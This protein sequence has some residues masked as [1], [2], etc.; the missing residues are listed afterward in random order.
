[1]GGHNLKRQLHQRGA[2]FPRDRWQKNGYYAELTWLCQDQPEGGG[3]VAE[4]AGGLASLTKV[5]PSIYYDLIARVCAGVPFMA[6]LLWDKRSEFG[7]VS[8]SKLALLL[9]ARRRR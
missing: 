4:E 7:E 8:W 1:M 6:V 3:A 2:S 9:G 5:V